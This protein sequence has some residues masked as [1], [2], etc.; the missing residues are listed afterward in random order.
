MANGI[1]AHIVVTMILHSG[2]VGVQEEFD[3]LLAR[4]GVT[5]VLRVLDKVVAKRVRVHGSKLRKNRVRRVAHALLRSASR[6]QSK[7]QGDIAE[8]RH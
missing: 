4:V 1:V 2:N 5:K 6:R 7:C 8:Q 3:A